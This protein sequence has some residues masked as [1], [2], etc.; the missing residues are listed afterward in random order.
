MALGSDVLGGNGKGLEDLD[1][2]L[3]ETGAG[4]W[5]GEALE[6]G[7]GELSGAGSQEWESA[8]SLA[9]QRSVEAVL[10]SLL[11]DDGCDAANKSRITILTEECL[12]V[13][14]RAKDNIGE[15]GSESKCLLKV[16][17][18]EIVFARLDW[19]LIE[20]CKSSVGVEEMKFFLCLNGR[21]GIDNEV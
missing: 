19:G 13:L 4:T 9:Q 21:E 15:S 14:E 3:A 17:D 6:C 10:F 12:N 2:D 18:R 20:V 1:R 8:G 7:E 11:T 5:N 16:G